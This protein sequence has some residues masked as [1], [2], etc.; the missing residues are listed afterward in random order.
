[1]NMHETAR[2]EVAPAKATT[3]TGGGFWDFRHVNQARSITFF[4]LGVVF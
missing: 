1:M 3:P 2:P 4:S